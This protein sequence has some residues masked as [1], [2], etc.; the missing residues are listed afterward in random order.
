MKGFGNDKLHLRKVGK[1]EANR[2]DGSWA[3]EIQ[4]KA[5]VRK[6]RMK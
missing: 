2:D 1:N 3:E 5:S 4:R 6:E